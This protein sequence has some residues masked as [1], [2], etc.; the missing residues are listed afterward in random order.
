V[1]LLPILLEAEP[2]SPGAAAAM[3][4]LRSWDRV[5]RPDGRAPLLFA[6]W[7]R[8]LS[9]LIQA[10]ELGPLFDAFW[11]VR[12]RLMEQILKRRPVWCDDVATEAVEGC[13]ELAS[14]ALDL[15][16]ADLAR[17]YGPDPADWRWGEAHP[18]RMAHAI[19]GDQPVLERVFDIEV[20][21]GGDSTTV[22]VGH[23]APRDQ[24]RPFASSHAASYRGLYD[25]ADLD[26][27]RWIAATGQ[28]GNPLSPHYRD[29]TRL[30]ARGESVPMT[31]RAD[32]YGRGAIGRQRLLPA[33]RT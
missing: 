30:W 26:R 23:F 31:R 6:A 5:M 14:R 21:S 13:A 3:T 1:D 17:R 28:S 32:A 24:R 4:E 9:R 8:E 16:L 12:P 19:F 10:D 11:G 20:P 2:M 25:L 22:N 7:Y 33:P 18:A 27:S 15:A 29:L